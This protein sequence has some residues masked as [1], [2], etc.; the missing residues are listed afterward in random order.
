M[1]A[2]RER[3]GRE[4]TIITRQLQHAQNHQ[5]QHLQEQGLFA[6]ENEPIQV[7]LPGGCATGVGCSV[8]KAD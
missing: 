3:K 4:E 8:H 6:M 1:R 5:K 2:Q 7:L